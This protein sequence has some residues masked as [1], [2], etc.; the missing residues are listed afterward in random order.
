MAGLPGGAIISGVA[1]K[2]TPA[3]V[4][5]KL[6]DFTNTSDASVSESSRDAG[7]GW[8]LY[9]TTGNGTVAV[10]YKLTT[11]SVFTVMTNL[12]SDELFTFA[13]GNGRNLDGDH[14]QVGGT[15]KPGHRISVLARTKVLKTIYNFHQEGSPHGPLMQAPTA[16]LWH[17]RRGR[18]GGRRGGFSG[19]RLLRV[20][21]CSLTSAQAPA[22]TASHHLPAWFRVAAKV[23]YWRQLGGWRGNGLGALC[24]KIGTTGYRILGCCMTLHPNWRLALSFH[25][26]LHTNGKIYGITSS[27]GAKPSNGVSNSFRQQLCSLH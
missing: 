1:F 14:T 6:Y 18:N 20:T 8:E 19:S 17:N 5:T 12:A 3:G 4:Y 23:L 9:G 21:K 26:L 27:G 16:L 25:A 10:L 22:R 11:A 15:F 7:T 13:V 24:F 2:I